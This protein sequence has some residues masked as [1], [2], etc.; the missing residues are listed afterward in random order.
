M[1]IEYSD[2]TNLSKNLQRASDYAPRIIDTWLHRQVGPALVKEMQLEAPVKTGKLRSEIR[3]IDA[4]RKVT[5]MPVGI[6]Y[7]VYV[8]EGT[9]PH[10]IRAKRKKALAWDQ[11]GKKMIRRQV[12]HPGTKPNPYMT[13]SAKVVMERLTPQLTGLTIKM[14]KTGNV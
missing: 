11:H 9:R 10:V 12:N 7:N 3:Q 13:D 14:L 4:P 6:D 1:G 5:V 2:V 8:V